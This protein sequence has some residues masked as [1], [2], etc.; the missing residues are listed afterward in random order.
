[1]GDIQH[2]RLVLGPQIERRGKLVLGDDGGGAPT[3]PDVLIAGA[4]TLPGLGVRAGLLRCAVAVAATAALPGLGVRAGG[5]RYKSNTQR[6]TVAAAGTAWQVAAA[7]DGAQARPAHQS[8]A[9]RPAAAQTRWQRGTDGA[10][11]V[12]H[13][14]PAVLAAQPLQGVAPWQ[15]AQGC[16]QGAAWP[17]QQALSM[18]LAR[19]AGW[20]EG[21]PSH[22]PVGFGHQDG[23][24]LPRAWRAAPWQA[25]HVLRLG[26]QGCHQSALALHR[27]WRAPWQ[28]GMPP[29]AGVSLRPVTPP[30]PPCY[31][32]ATLGRIV[33]TAL[34]DGS[35]R[36]VFVC[37]R[38]APAWGVAVP[39]RRVYIVLN[40]I[41]LVRVDDGAPL[42]ALGFSAALDVD[43][44]TWQWSAVL[45]ESAGPH[46][47]RGAD[48]MPPEVL[49]SING[50][51]LRLVVERV[52]RD[53]RFLPQVR[54]SVSG[55]GRAAVL[56]SPW[57]PV[58]QH[59][60]QVTQRTAEQLAAEVLTI[61]NVGIGWGIDWQLPAWTV[62]AGLWTFSGS[63]M[64]ALGD[65]AS[66][67]GAT[68]QPHP[69][70]AVLRMLA[71]Y[72][73][74]PWEWD[75]VAPDYLLPRDAVQALGTEFFD[76]PAYT[77]VFVGG[78]QAG[79]FGPVVRGGTVGDVLAPQATHVLITDPVAQRLRGTAVLSDT[80]RQR[81]V[82]LSMQVLPETGLIVPG[83]L[84]QVGSGAQAMLGMVRATA[85]EWARPRL[86]Q[87]IEL[88]VHDL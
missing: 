48:G 19:L 65:I 84:V 66:A 31:D 60:G 37:G 68:I 34:A 20:Q 75:Q 21:L 86:R 1:M 28:E 39:V 57:A 49:A 44:W 10:A 82:S 41:T 8:T 83:K 59:G 11:Q 52:Q 35:G 85:I 74:P 54:Y 63:Y 9:A 30:K 61:N 17:H 81:R 51:P 78:T 46:L 77:G 42:H 16:Q 5:L 18:A 13:P 58:L 87:N 26:Y 33:F 6:P 43:S 38:A 24:R 76:K 88:E 23:S 56:A 14:L 4:P 2:A 36:V 3:L 71:R 47:A 67:V 80:G 70:D 72:P 32:P 73:R 25:G 15:A 69:T 12:A 40:N 55:R 22:V 79:G 53:G 50:Q 29:P 62:P 45:H 64:D 27:R 7:G